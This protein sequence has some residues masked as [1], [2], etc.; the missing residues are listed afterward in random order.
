MSGSSKLYGNAV[1]QPEVTGLRLK[2]EEIP[3]RRTAVLEGARLGKAGGTG[4][5]DTGGRGDAASLPGGGAGG[6]VAVKLPDTHAGGRCG[7]W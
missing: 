6:A 7:L 5:R 1:E 3:E 2:M 4:G